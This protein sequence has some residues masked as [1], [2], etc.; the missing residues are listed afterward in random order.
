MKKNKKIYLV[1]SGTGGHAAPILLMYKKLLNTPNFDPTILH[2]GSDIENKLFLNTKSKRI[3]SAK[4]D[5]N[6]TYKK[7]I[8]YPITLLGIIQAKAL[9][10]FKRPDLI[11][12]KGGYGSV[13][14]LFMARFFKIPYFIHE[15]DSHIGL[16]NKLFA[17]KAEK[18]FLGFPKEVYNEDVSDEKYKYTG[19]IVNALPK[20]K[21]EVK[22]TIYI[23]GGS[24][25]AES[26]N[27]VVYKIIDKL[28]DKY[29]VYHQVGDNNILKAEEIKSKLDKNEES[30]KVFGFSAE[31]SKEAFAKADLVV[32]RA[33]ANTIGEI[34]K[35][36]KASILIP[37]PHAAQNHQ[38][39]NA[40]YLEKSGSAFLIKENNLNEKYL[41]ERIEYILSNKRNADVLGEKIFK[42]IKSDGADTV[43]AEIIKSNKD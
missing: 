10:L 25:G 37:Y 19:Q 38:M 20:I 33:G 39:K 42:A 21:K 35:N 4:F 32:A 7:L 11:F 2:S 23:T 5:R 6:S 29:K 40:K 12:S 14:V 22:K 17:G 43:Y 3:I 15:S 9:L 31:L 16:A 1:S 41:L 27:G 8:S 28:V 13:P 30:Y 34:A 18:V 36:K 26:V 24:L